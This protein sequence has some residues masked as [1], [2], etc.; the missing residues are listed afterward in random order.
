MKLK[1]ILSQLV[2]DYSPLNIHLKFSDVYDITEYQKIYQTEYTKEY[3]GERE[4][5]S[6]HE[7]CKLYEVANW[8]NRIERYSGW[9]IHY[10]IRENSHVYI[11]KLEFSLKDYGAIIGRLGI[12]RG[13]IERIILEKTLFLRSIIK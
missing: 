10:A 6:L 5:V 12:I 13:E 2:F 1:D 3:K 7:E 11:C 4:F 8:Y 9:E